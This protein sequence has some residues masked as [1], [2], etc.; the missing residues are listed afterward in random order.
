LFRFLGLNPVWSVLLPLC[1]C[2]LVCFCEICLNLFRFVVWSEQRTRW[3][4]S[5]ARRFTKPTSRR[6]RYGFSSFVP[7][8]TLVGF[9]GSLASSISSA[10]DSTFCCRTIDLLMLCKLVLMKATVSRLTVLLHCSIIFH[11]N[12]FFTGCCWHHSHDIGSQI[13]AENASGRWWRY[14]KGLLVVYALCCWTKVNI[15]HFLCWITLMANNKRW[16]LHN[17]LCFDYFCSGIVVTNDGNSIL[18]EIDIAHPAAKVCQILLVSQLRNRWWNYQSTI[19][20]FFL[21]NGW[22]CA[23]RPVYIPYHICV[24]MCSLWFMLWVPCT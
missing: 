14:A 6:P 3:S 23:A 10:V 21:Y 19:T 1:F 13:H 18:R 15:N 9:S 12:I 2:S 8:A 24:L 4:G 7:F 22:I 20:Y 17:L 5:L 11:V 16:I